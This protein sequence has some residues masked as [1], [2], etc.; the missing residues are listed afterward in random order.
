MAQE[1]S[2]YQIP[3]YLADRVGTIA[4][5]LMPHITN[6]RF[7]RLDDMLKLRSRRI[8]CVFENTAHSH[9]ISAVLRT[10]EAFGFQDVVFVFQEPIPNQVVMRDSVE[11]GASKW[12]TVHAA[13]S[14]DACASRL[15]E[16][17]YA[18]LLVSKPDFAVAGQHFQANLPLFTDT[19]IGE[20]AFNA[21]AENQP[22][23]LIFGNEG[24]GVSSKWNRHIHGVLQVGMV[25]FTESLNLSVAAGILLR[26]LRIWVDSQPS[27]GISAEDR[28]VLL[29]QWVL[30]A[31]NGGGHIIRHNHR[32]LIDYF[33]FIRD[34]AF[35]IDFS[36]ATAHHCG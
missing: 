17:G 8:I 20:S 32:D 11:R 28:S 35:R 15:R 24:V 18:L 1:L 2:K 7:Q 26:S 33:K 12:L 34:S 21:F 3:P 10:I 23:A 27:P 16:L 19:E 14:I 6:Q 9:N 30:R 36:G 31:C 29:D 25:G 5:T 4:Q 13:N 22:L